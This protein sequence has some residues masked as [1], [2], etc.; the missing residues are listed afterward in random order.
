MPLKFY[1]KWMRIPRPTVNE[2]NSNDEDQCSCLSS[3]INIIFFILS[4]STLVIALN[5]KGNSK[6]SKFYSIQDINDLVKLTS[7]ENIISVCIYL[8]VTLAVFSLLFCFR[9]FC[10][11]T[12]GLI[13]DGVLIFVIIIIN[14]IL[15]LI[16]HINTPMYLENFKSGMNQTLSEINSGNSA[17]MVKDCKIF[18]SISDSFECC[19]L[20]G[21]GDFV[22]VT[23]ADICCSNKQFQ[24]GCLKL[25]A[26]E[27]FSKT[28]TRILTPNVV[29][30]CYELLICIVLFALFFC[31]RRAS[32]STF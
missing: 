8:N 19:A 20:N 15:M 21:P 17:H 30:L 5:L 16:L 23:L 29:V 24:K 3:I 27:V 22:N 28:S 10:C 26:D 7:L 31:K 32:H 6:F 13:L 4:I 18:K 2:R 12:I 25:I 9:N 1:Q 11:G 14:G